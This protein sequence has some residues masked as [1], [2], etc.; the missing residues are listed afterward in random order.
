MSFLDN[1][2]RGRSDDRENGLYNVSGNSFGIDLGSCNVKL[3]NHTTGKIRSQKN[4]IAVQDR[5][6][7]MAW[8]DKAYEMYERTPSSIHVSR[9]VN[10]GVIADIGNMSEVI[11]SFLQDEQRGVLRPAD[12][13]IAIPTDVTQVQRRAFYELIRDAGVRARKIMGAERAVA[14]ALGLGVDVRNTHGILLVDVGYETTEVTVM[15]M[16]G[17]V[18]SKL[19]KIGGRMFDTSIVNAVRREFGLAIGTKTAEALRMSLASDSAR[20]GEAL[21]E[22]TGLTSAGN[23]RADIYGRDIVTGLPAARTITQ[24]FVNRALHEHFLMIAENVRTILERTPPEL[25]A[26]IFRHGLFLTGGGSMAEDL[27]DQIQQEIR[28]D[29]NLA[30]NPVVTVVIGLSQIMQ[31]SQY[32]QFA[33]TIEGLSR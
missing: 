6:T 4:M 19:L 13:F 29:V 14:G 8:G 22:T 21:P 7:T 15:S 25:S 30:E 26:D 17:I 12:F 1:M 16:G 28:I 5:K 18:L 31:R 32:R 27:V 11:R 23:G 33:Y 2:L 24:D 3:Y 9:P 10:D 20:K